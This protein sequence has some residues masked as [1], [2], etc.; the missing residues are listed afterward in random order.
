MYTFNQPYLCTQLRPPPP[1]TEALE[2]KT[3]R[4]T[5]QFNHAHR[6]RPLTAGNKLHNHAVEA[7]SGPRSRW[8][9]TA[10]TIQYMYTMRDDIST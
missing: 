3:E 6:I 2:R 1:Q 10:C 4:K 5:W 8:L 9:A 7:P